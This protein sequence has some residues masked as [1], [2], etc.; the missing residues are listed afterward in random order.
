MKFKFLFLLFPLLS[1]V[2]LGACIIKNKNQI[3]DYSLN[4]RGKVTNNSKKVEPPTVAESL[5]EE[6]EEEVKSHSH[7]ELLQAVQENNLDLVK[8]ILKDKN[9]DIN[10]VNSKGQSPLLIATHLNRIEIAKLLILSGAD[11]NQQDHISDSP[12][13][14]AAAQGKTD[15]LQFIIDHA[16]PNQQ[17]FNRFG[18]NSIIPAAEKGHLANVKIL[19]KEGKVDINHQNNYGYTALIEAI[20]LRDGSSL[21]L[22]IVKELL[23]HGADKN[24]RDNQG[25]KAKDYAIELGYHN[26]ANLLM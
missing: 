9:Y 22:S 17:I 19:L 5:N 1:L 20:A 6:S 15:I 11:V 14:Y 8:L 12:Y 25:K 21:Y 24:I 10:E 26:I 7:G 23:N 4:S 16:T 3:T 2:L 18:G 13:L